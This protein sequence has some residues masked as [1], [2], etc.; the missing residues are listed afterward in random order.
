VREALLH[1]RYRPAEAGGQP[2]RQL[3]EQPFIFKLD[4]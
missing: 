3:V 4:R 1:S 2:V